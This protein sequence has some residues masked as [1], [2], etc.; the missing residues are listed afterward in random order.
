MTTTRPHR[1]RSGRPPSPS[2]PQARAVR[3]SSWAMRIMTA[4]AASGT[5]PTIVIQRS[6]P[7]APVWPT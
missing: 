5:G 4:S 2:S 1:T 6:S 7:A 3:P